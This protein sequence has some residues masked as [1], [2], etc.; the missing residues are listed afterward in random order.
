M[1][2]EGQ[3]QGA[4]DAADKIVPAH[5]FVRQNEQ[6][7]V[8]QDVGNADLPTK[9]V[10]EDHAQAGDAAAQQVVGQEKCIQRDT[11]DAGSQRDG[12]VALQLFIHWI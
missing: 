4:E 12:Q 2:E 10:E 7:D 8:E 6:R 5:E 11:G 9:Q 3:G 1:Q